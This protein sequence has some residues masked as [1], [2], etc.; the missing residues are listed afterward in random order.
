MQ[1]IN[2]PSRAG[3]LASA[4]GSGLNQLA[5]L[6]LAELTKRYDKQVEKSQFAKTWEPILGKHS[7][8][9]LSNLSPDERKNAMQDI[10]SLLQLN[11]Q[12]GSQEQ[13]RGM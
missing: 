11:E 9:F 8:N 5:E 1:I 4:F 7:A 2:D 13:A 6:K 3:S 12:P 10:G